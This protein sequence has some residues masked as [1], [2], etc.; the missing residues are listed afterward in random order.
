NVYNT[1]YDNGSTYTQI[2][3]L[4]NVYTATSIEKYKTGALKGLDFIL[5]SQYKNGGWPQFYPLESDYS[6]CITYND[7]VFEGIM[8]LLKDIKDNKPEYAFVD[9]KLRAKLNLA[10]DK[11]MDCIIKT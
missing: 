8:E 3:V 2:A 9:N 1:T 11:G 5:E 10:Y 6:R 4:A 7:G